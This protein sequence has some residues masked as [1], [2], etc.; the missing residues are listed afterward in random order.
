MY[1]CTI[2]R[3]TVEASA[4]QLMGY[5][6]VNIEKSRGSMI[7]ELSKLDADEV[8]EGCWC[9]ADEA[10]SMFQLVI[11]DA[12]VCKLCDRC[13]ERLFQESLRA[14]CMVAAKVKTREDL[15][16]IRKRAMAHDG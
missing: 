13:I 14:T 1:M 9:S 2:M 5:E 15:A 7:V 4:F 3:I 6:K 10:L 11:S 8:C 16:I 12:C